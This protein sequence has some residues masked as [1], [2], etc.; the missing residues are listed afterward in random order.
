MM[1]DGIQNELSDGRYS[2]LCEGNGW[3]QCQ[4]KRY[5][6]C[7][8]YMRLVSCGCAEI[9]RKKEAQER[10]W[11]EEKQKQEK[12]KLQQER[13]QLEQEERQ[14]NE[15]QQAKFDLSRDTLNQ[16]Y[17]E[18]E[19]S[20]DYYEALLLRDLTRDVNYGGVDDRGHL[21]AKHHIL[22]KMEREGVGNPILQKLGAPKKITNDSQLPQ[23]MPLFVMPDGKKIYS[24]K[25]LTVEMKKSLNLKK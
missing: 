23:N 6:Y 9:R 5:V 13:E 8:G 25:D 1:E 11:L 4:G 16:L 18:K 19:D 2:S 12:E 21:N 22:Q 20:K 17:H 24:E 3:C 10:S 15:Q 14:R 7:D